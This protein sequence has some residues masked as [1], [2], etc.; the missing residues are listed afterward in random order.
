MTIIMR[1][2]NYELEDARHN[3]IEQQIRPW[4]V[5]DQTVLDLLQSCR[6]SNSCRRTCARWLS[7]TSNC[8]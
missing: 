8:P 5:L 3:M 2:D 1:K 4:E 6:A 7:S